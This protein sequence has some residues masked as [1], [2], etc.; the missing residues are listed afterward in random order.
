[1]VIVAA[2]GIMGLSNE[3]RNILTGS[4][5][6]TSVNI[7]PSQPIPC[8]FTLH[9]GWNMVSFFCIG[10]WVPRDKVLE[11]VNN[12]YSKI[13]YYS[14]TDTSDPW[15][16]YNPNLPNWTVQQLMY[17]DRY[18][19]YW[20]YMT[21]DNTYFYN[22]SEKLSTLHLYNGWNLV[23][24]TDANTSNIND[25]L[26]GLLYT[27][28]ITYDNLGNTLLVYSPNSSSN[29]LNKFDTYKS[30]WINSTTNQS[31]TILP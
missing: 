3:N 25:S 31:W 5:V 26:N 4:Y 18:T 22:G 9:S 6:T 16:S 12:S 11:S 21:S 13:F 30:Y 24:Y 14:A 15:K 20:I 27:L 10:T 19:G 23:G 8:D 29:T 7:I 17:M 1:M 28:V 2:V